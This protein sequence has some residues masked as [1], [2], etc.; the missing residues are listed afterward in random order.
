MA[1]EAYLGIT[2]HFIDDN[3]NMRKLTLGCLALYD[4]AH[5][6]ENLTDA[7]SQTLE[8][9][10]PGRTVAGVHDNGSNMVAMTLPFPTFRCVAHTIQ[11]S[12]TTAL[13]RIKDVLARVRLLVSF[14]LRLTP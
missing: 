2:I 1:T 5:T 10:V 7:I 4:M 14:D 13:D 12:V 11:L 6:A 9:F 8:K 3:W